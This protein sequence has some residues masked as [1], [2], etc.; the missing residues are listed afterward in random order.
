MIDTNQNG[1]FDWTD[2]LWSIAMIKDGNRY[3][4]ADELGIVAINWSDAVMTHGDMHG[5]DRQYDDCLYEGVYL[6]PKCVAVSDEHFAI[7][8]YNK[9]GIMMKGGE[10]IPTFGGVMGHLDME[11]S[12]PM[13][14]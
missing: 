10:T 2:N 12:N 4:T 3:Y 11:E 6:Y 9:N 13:L 1:Y 7:T 5:Q 8:G 14:K